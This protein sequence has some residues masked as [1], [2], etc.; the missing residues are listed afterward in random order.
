V[1]GLESR[2]LSL[3]AE[4]PLSRLELFSYKAS[5]IDFSTYDT[6]MSVYT[7]YTTLKARSKAA[8][9]EQNCNENSVGREYSPLF[10][11]FAKSMVILPTNFGWSGLILETRF[12]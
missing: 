10:S 5:P 3:T 12:N 11:I 9:T 7:F 6:D 8:L 4:T 2:L 1:K